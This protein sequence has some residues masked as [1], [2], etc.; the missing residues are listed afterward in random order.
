MPCAR[1]CC[2]GDRLIHVLDLH[3]S[4]T[5]PEHAATEAGSGQPSYCTLPL[6]HPPKRLGDAIN[7]L[8]YI[9]NDGHLFSCRSPAVLQ[10]AFHV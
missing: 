9:S 7:G 3:P 5:G 8:G 2:G 1:V 10:Q 6:F 4:Y